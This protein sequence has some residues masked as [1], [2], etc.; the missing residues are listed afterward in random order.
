MEVTAAAEL[1]HMPPE[2]HPRLW[3]LR[4]SDQCLKESVRASVVHPPVGDAGGRDLLRSNPGNRCMSDHRARLG[5]DPPHSLSPH[6]VLHTVLG[7]LTYM[8]TFVL[9]KTNKSLDTY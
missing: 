2:S 6:F 3:D 9:P 8:V 5:S 7:A 1:G 4:V